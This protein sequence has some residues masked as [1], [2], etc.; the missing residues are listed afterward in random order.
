M[1][2]ALILHLAVFKV[3]VKP[4][5]LKVLNYSISIIFIKL[6]LISIMIRSI[7]WIP[8]SLQEIAILLESS[9]N[10]SIFWSAY[11]A[12]KSLLVLIFLNLNLILLEKKT[13]RNRFQYCQR[14][15]NSFITHSLSFIF[16]RTIYYKKRSSETTLSQSLCV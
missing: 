1:L 12:V 6:F 10:Y 8:I 7:L 9:L 16:I 13:I 5:V 14:I 4:K 3:L 2:L 11:N 15:I